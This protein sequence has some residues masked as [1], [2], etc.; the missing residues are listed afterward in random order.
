MSHTTRSIIFIGYK[1]LQSLVD[2]T[3]AENL[4]FY[5]GW[6]NQLD[7]QLRSTSELQLSSMESQNRLSGMLELAFLKFNLSRSTSV[8]RLLLDSTPVFLQLALAETAWQPAPPKSTSVSLAHLFTSGCYELA[9]FA[10]LDSLCSMLYALPQAVDYDTTVQPFGTDIHIVEWVYGCP[11]ELQMVLADI[12]AR[13]NR[14]RAGKDFDWQR[15]EQRLKSWKPAMSTSEEDQSWRAV[16]R[17]AVQE[18]WRHTLLIYLYMA[19][20]EITSDDARVQ[21]SVRQVFQLTSTVKPTEA[22]SI[23]IHLFAQYLVAGACAR[24]ETQRAVARER[25][26]GGFDEGLM[27]LRS[28]DFVPVLDHLWHGAAANGQPIRWSD[29]ARS[30]QATLPILI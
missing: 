21:A 29:Y 20:C 14:S 16:A 22:P 3:G 8:Y 17:L 28:S 10:L 27:I 15:M 12:N 19:L 11:V 9:H 1:V 13:F 30:R 7:Q 5:V 2:G 6:L 26:G 18:S 25:L 23:N 24:S 4:S